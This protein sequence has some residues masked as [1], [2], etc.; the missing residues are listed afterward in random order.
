M[1]APHRGAFLLLGGASAGDRRQARGRSRKAA[2]RSQR[3]RYSW[4]SGMCRR[5]AFPHLD[6]GS[7]ALATTAVGMTKNSGSRRPSSSGLPFR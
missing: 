7:F 3:S 2:T 6:L 4:W 1:K 5:N